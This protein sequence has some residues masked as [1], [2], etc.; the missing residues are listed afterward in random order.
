LAHLT[1]TL[2]AAAL[3]PAVVICRSF[4]RFDM[5]ALIFHRD[6]GLKGTTLR[7]LKNEIATA[8]VTVALLWLSAVLLD[9]QLGLDGLI[10]WSATGALAAVNPILQHVVAGLWRRRVVSVLPDRFCQPRLATGTAARPDLLIVYLE[11]LDRR[12]ADP[13]VFGQLYDRLSRF[14][15]EG[16][17]F[18]RVGQLLGTGWS[19]AGMVASQAGVPVL[20]RGLRLDAGTE[21]VTRFMPGVTFLGD[22]LQAKGY[23]PHYV[24]GGDAGFGG[25]RTMYANHGIP[26]MTDL[27]DLKAMFPAAEVDAASHGWIQD[28]QMVLDAARRLYPGLAEGAEPFALIVE[29]IGPH[30][31]K[32]YLSR[33]STASGRAETTTDVAASAR[34]MIDEVM[35]FVEDLVAEQCHRGRDFRV[36]LLSDHLNHTPTLPK[37]GA[38]FAG[39]NTV[40]FWG[41]PTRRGGVVDRAASM[42]DVF[43]TLLHWLGWAEGEVAAGLGRSLLAH[44]PTLTEEFGLPTL[45]RMIA[46]DATLSNLI[47]DGPKVTLRPP[48][49]QQAPSA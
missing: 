16:L 19:L 10:V 38:G 33:R 45:D 23:L 12:F 14:A 22:V 24:V 29:T 1:L 7:S 3:L 48:L 6:F 44:P 42:V 13:E 26:Q 25:I 18:T 9:G 37:G 2:A 28:D 39:F 49:A 36:V 8:V 11:G 5:V 17:S 21:V 34:H 35:D 46:G 27:A 43:P 15:E 47:W 41:D 31:P 30:G 4:G 20:P 40:I 32:G